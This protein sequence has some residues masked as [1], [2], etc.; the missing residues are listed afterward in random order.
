VILRGIL[1]EPS[2]QCVSRYA[3]ILAARKQPQVSTYLCLNHR[4]LFFSQ[5]FLHFRAGL[6]VLVRVLVL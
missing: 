2:M 1:T 5:E 4:Y 3:S 6:S